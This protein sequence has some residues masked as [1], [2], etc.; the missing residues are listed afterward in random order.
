MTHIEE[1]HRLQETVGQIPPS[2]KCDLCEF[3]SES[4]DSLEEH[5]EFNHNANKNRC[6]LCEHEAAG[7]VQLKEHVDTAHSSDI[8]LHVHGGKAQPFGSSHRSSF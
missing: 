8:Q 7:K 3:T 4:S 5:K 6:N 1:T 2:H